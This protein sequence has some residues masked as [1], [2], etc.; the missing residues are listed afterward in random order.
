[1]YKL[2]TTYITFSQKQQKNTYF[3]YNFLFIKY[4]R[5]KYK[6]F[7]NMTKK[8]YADIN[9][10]LSIIKTNTGKEDIES[11]YVVYNKYLSPTNILKK[12]KTFIDCGS[13]PGG[14]LKVAIENGMTGYGIT[15]PKDNNM[16]IKMMYTQNVIYGDL[17]DEHFVMSLKNKIKEK[18]DFVNMGA[19][20]Y[21]KLY[22]G[23]D[24]ISQKQLFI[25]QFYIV[26][27]FLKEKG[28]FMFIC[29]IYYTFYTFISLMK[30]FVGVE[31]E[32]EFLPVQPNFMTSQIYVLIKNISKIDDV[33]F[34]RL[35]CVMTRQYLPIVKL[36]DKYFDDIFD[37]PKINIESL[38]TTY[39][40]KILSDCKVSN[41]IIYAP[42]I[43]KLGLDVINKLNYNLQFL[44]YEDVPYYFKN[45][46][47]YN[48][49]TLKITQKVYDKI[50]EIRDNFIKKN[51]IDNIVP[52]YGMYIK[53][54][55]IAKKIYKLIMQ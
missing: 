53:I 33:L 48:Q 30:L 27:E 19:V 1:M 51:N 21:D 9:E 29:D 24:N 46:K 6:W 45:S 42:F 40:L 34:N 7:E 36:I 3:Y 2:N 44:K 23:T 26:K 12:N 10:L 22:Q 13:A 49:H 41:N 8:E 54:N 25:N 16:A 31:C 37:S 39:Y 28:S 50:K 32:I 47:L 38:K 17:L 55:K 43:P 14:F 15:L 11:Y 4:A 52:D 18:V 5:N 35:Y 20:F